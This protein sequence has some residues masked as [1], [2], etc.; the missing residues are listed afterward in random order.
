ML[1]RHAVAKMIRGSFL[2]ALLAVACWFFYPSNAFDYKIQKPL[3]MELKDVKA[4]RVA[5]IG[6]TSRKPLST[7]T[8]L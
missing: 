3:H 6:E 1:G 2:L 7:L 4:K 8:A 5:I